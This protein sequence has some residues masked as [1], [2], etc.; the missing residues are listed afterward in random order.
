MFVMSLKKTLMEH[1]KTQIHWEWI[2]S[3]KTTWVFCLF[4]CLV[5]VLLFASKSHKPSLYHWHVMVWLEPWVHSGVIQIVKHLSAVLPDHLHFNKM[6]CGCTKQH[7]WNAWNLMYWW[8]TKVCCKA[9]L[10]YSLHKQSLPQH[11]LCR[12]SRKCPASLHHRA[13]LATLWNKFNALNA[14]CQKSIGLLHQNH[15]VMFLVSEL[16]IQIIFCL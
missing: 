14:M 7:S 15:N 2:A 6:I 12:A 3:T 11:P 16:P 13:I 8:G 10:D 1:E 4:V 9:K 5:F